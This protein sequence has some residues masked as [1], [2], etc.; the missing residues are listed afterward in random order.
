MKLLCAIKYHVLDISCYL[1]LVGKYA[2][3]VIH[4]KIESDLSKLS[5]FH[6][7]VEEK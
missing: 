1:R 3:D 2:N 5:L 7:S 6:R 4:P